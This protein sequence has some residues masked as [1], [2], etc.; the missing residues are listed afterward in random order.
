MNNFFVQEKEKERE[1]LRPTQT[2]KVI[3][4]FVWRLCKT[5]LKPVSTERYILQYLI[6]LSVIFH[7]K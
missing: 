5:Y 6:I 4:H 7:E 1:N 2:H 3:G